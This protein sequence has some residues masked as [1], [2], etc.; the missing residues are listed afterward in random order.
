LGKDDVE[1]SRAALDAEGSQLEVS[2]RIARFSEPVLDA[3][4]QAVLDAARAAQLAGLE[5]RVVGRVSVTAT[6]KGP[7][8]APMLDAR[9]EGRELAFRTIE[10]LSLDAEVGYDGQTRQVTARSVEATAPWGHLTGS[11][12]V[13]LERALR[14][15]PCAR[16]ASISRRSC[17]VSA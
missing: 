5:D 3:R 16:A 15:R 14:R 9:V 17:A 13:S 12:L 6:A 8:T 4:L 10:A 7:A 2:G 11:G 1:I